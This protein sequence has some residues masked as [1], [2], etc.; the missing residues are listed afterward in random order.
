MYVLLNVLTIAVA[1][2]MAPLIIGLLITD[3]RDRRRYNRPTLGDTG[4]TRGHRGT[5]GDN[6]ITP[7]RER[8]HQALLPPLPQE[9]TKATE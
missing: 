2:V 4:D 9:N 3:S 8:P 6:R 5:R 7:I 1:G